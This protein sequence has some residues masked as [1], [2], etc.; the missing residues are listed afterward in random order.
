MESFLLQGIVTKRGNFP[1]ENFQ[2]GGGL[3]FIIGMQKPNLALFF[4]FYS[5][6]RN[7]K[8]MIALSLTITCIKYLPYTNVLAL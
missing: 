3:W 7:G 4:F 2:S 8:Q 5:K 1:Q 6:E